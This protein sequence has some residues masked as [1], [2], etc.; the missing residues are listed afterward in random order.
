MKRLF[1]ISLIANVVLIGCVAYLWPVSQKF[2]KEQDPA[3]E[4]EQEINVVMLG[5]SITN[6]GDWKQ[7]LNRNDVFNG[8]IPGWTSQ[9][10]SWVI[11]DFI[12]GKTPEICFFMAGI[13]DY[14]LGISTERIVQNI[15]ANLDSIQGFGTSPVFTT[16]LYQRGN[17]RVNR[18]IDKL[19][20]EVIDY[21]KTKGYDVLDLRPLLCDEEDILDQYVLPDNTH[22]EKEAYPVWA[23]AVKELLEEKGFDEIDDKRN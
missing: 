9:Q 17:E 18:E 11:E 16:T 23:Q 21:C 8:G 13:N 6:H 14:T 7:L 19:N 15:C 2:E 5:N 1:W 12:G 20:A 10:L 22:L 4:S 3:T